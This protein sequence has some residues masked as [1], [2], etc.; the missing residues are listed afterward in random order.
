M[1]STRRRWGWRV[2]VM[3]L[4]VGLLL[5]STN[6]VAYALSNPESHQAIL[7][8][9]DQVLGAIAAIG[10]GGE[11]NHALRWD[12]ALPAATRFVILTAF[13]SDAVLDKNTGLVW[14]N[15]PQTEGLLWGSAL[16]TCLNKNVGGQIGWRLPSIPELAS[17]ID[18]SVAD[19]G[20]TLPPGHPFLNVAPNVLSIDYWSATTFS[21]DTTIAWTVRF[22]NGRVGGANK[23]G[24]SLQ[25]WCVRG[26]MNAD[27][28]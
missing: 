26:G 8:R 9:L 23:T 18:R 16:S 11:E 7:D 1:R 2:G 3:V 22:S 25:L 24:G 17:L 12:Q 27:A 4:S 13:N 21:P 5:M 28:Y 6:R 10:G 14:E 20:P 15:S 19:P